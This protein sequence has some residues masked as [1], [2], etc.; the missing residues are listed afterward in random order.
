MTAVVV[1]NP[2]RRGGFAKSGS[3]IFIKA[4]VDVG[5]HE[6]LWE[7]RKLQ[8]GITDES[9]IMRRSKVGHPRYCGIFDRAE[10]ETGE[11]SQPRIAELW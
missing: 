3:A 11:R 7:V 1:G 8:A 9:E 10:C 2:K 6:M 5:R 4:N